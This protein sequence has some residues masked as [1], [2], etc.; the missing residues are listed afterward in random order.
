MPR[1]VSAPTSVYT[2]T[3]RCPRSHADQCVAD[4]VQLFCILR[5]IRT[6]ASVALTLAY[7]DV[8]RLS[9]VLARQDKPQPSVTFNGITTPLMNRMQ[10]VAAKLLCNCH[11]Y[12]RISPLLCDLHR[13]CVPE[14]KFTFGR[15]S[16]HCC[17]Q[18]APEYLSRQLQW[19]V[20]DEPRR[21][22]RSASSQRLNS[23]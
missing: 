3:V 22:L 1:C 12:D 15:C 10:S 2:S 5:H 21:R 20:Y 7:P 19:A 4:R 16:V 18:T 6:A 13:L 11:K 17:N 8:A 23:T 14:H 9:D